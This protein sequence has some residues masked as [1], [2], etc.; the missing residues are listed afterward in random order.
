MPKRPFELWPP[1]P[2]KGWSHDLLDLAN[3][4]VVPP[5]DNDFIMPAGVLH[6]D[7]RHCPRGAL[8]R[9]YRPLTIRPERPRGRLPVLPGSWLWGG[10]L[11]AHFGHFIAE[12]SARLWPLPALHDRLDGILFIPKRPRRGETVLAFQ[13]DFIS[14]FGFDLPIRV[15]TEP[16]RVERLFVPGQGFGLGAIS[17]GTGP[18]RRTVAAHFGRAVAPSGGTRLYISR[19][20]IGKARGSIVGE[21]RLEDALRANGY[22]I[23]HPQR[24][25][26]A[27]QVARYKAAETILACE[28][29]ALHVV[30]MVARADQRIG[31]ILRRRSQ[32]TELIARHVESFSGRAPLIFDAL[33]RN[34]KREGERRKHGWQGE[35]DMA[36]LQSMLAASGFIAPGGARWASPDAAE[37]A[38]ELG[39]E[40]VIAKTFLEQAPAPP[41]AETAAR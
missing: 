38:A 13:R 29:S 19:S 11:W 22:E 12:S 8:W 26:L 3:P 36:R 40:F 35:H 20:S 30:A 37:I 28:G 32:A 21:Q 5:Q 18:F 16:M 24:H 7:G 9:K 2:D 27:T 15:A 41:P 31:V 23:F 33:L 34:W 39:P 17:A 14:L 4:Y 10:L 1:Q 6:A 25:D